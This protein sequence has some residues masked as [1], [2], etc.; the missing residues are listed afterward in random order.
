MPNYDGGDWDLVV[1]GRVIEGFD[2]ASDI[3][4]EG[5]AT[6]IEASGQR[7]VG[8]N[9]RRNANGVDFSFSILQVSRDKEFVED[10]VNSEREVE[11]KVVL[12]RN[13]D[14]YDPGQEVA[15]GTREGV[16]NGGGTN[17]GQDEQEPVTYD[18]TGIGY[19][20]DYKDRED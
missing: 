9:H 1:A 8:W 14:A 5:D 16:V 3:S 6:P 19:I 17:V 20:R 13:I 10:L 18:V 12:A 11:V 15:L 2:S 7:R 4:Q